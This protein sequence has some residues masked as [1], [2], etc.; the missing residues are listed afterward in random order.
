MA[1]E[2]AQGSASAF[3]ASAIDAL[4]NAAKVA[5]KVRAKKLRYEIGTA[6]NQIAAMIPLLDQPPFE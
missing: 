2:L 1:N 5:E 4:D 3:L 6:R